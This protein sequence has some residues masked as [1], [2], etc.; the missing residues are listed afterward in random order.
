MKLFHHIKTNLLF[1]LFL[2]FLF[3]NGLL[4][5]NCD[6]LNDE[7]TTYQDA[8]YKVRSY[9]FKIRELVSTPSS[10]WINRILQL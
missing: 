4:Q 6:K 3:S 8:I 1:N 7:F 2:I 5:E 10:S 9:E